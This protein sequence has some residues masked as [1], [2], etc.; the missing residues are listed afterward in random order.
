MAAGVSECLSRGQGIP[1]ITFIWNQTRH[2]SLSPIQWASLA[3][4][5]YVYIAKASEI[6]KQT[7]D[8][9]K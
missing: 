5:T 4:E 7:I 8:K 1:P 3:W 9:Q 6:D 2:L